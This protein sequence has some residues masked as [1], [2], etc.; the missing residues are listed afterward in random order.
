MTKE[1]LINKITDCLCSEYQSV[2]LINTEDMTMRIFEAD[3]ETSVPD[4]ITTVDAMNSYPKARDWYVENV[5]VERD[6]EKVYALSDINTI[7]KNLSENKAY[8]VEY[9][10]NCAGSMNYNQLCYYKLDTKEGESACILLGFRDIDIRKKAEID[11]LTGLY[12]RQVFFQKA[13]KMVSENPDVQFDIIMSDI[14]DF[15]KVNET[16]GAHVA[17]KILRWTGKFLSPFMNDDLLIGRYGGDQIV[18]FG[19]HEVIKE[20]GNGTMSHFLTLE[21]ENGLPNVVV[22]FGVY[23]NINHSV[24]MVANCDNAHIAVNSI[25]YQYDQIVAKY[26][27]NLKGKMNTQ[28]KIED[29]MHQSLQNGDFK[30]FYQPKHDAITG[31]IIGAEALVRWIHPEYG[32]MS[33]GDFIPLFEKNGFVV[34]IDAF[35]W[36]KSCENIRKWKDEGIRTVPISV[37]ASKLTFAMPD[38]ITKMQTHVMRNI[39]S[40]CDLHI[41]ITETLMTENIEELVKKLNTMRLLGYQVELDDFGS[42]FSSMNALSTLPLDVVKLDMSFMKEFGDEKKSK[43]LG[44]CINLAKVLGYKTVSEGVETKD[45]CDV[46]GF[47]GVDYIQGYHYSKPLPEEEFKEYLRKHI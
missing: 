22:K 45:Q 12:T 23:E 44:A 31:K 14:V 11:D 39:L 27:N 7:L 9:N 29:S 1:E 17:D 25:K 4:A 3:Y 36:G 24:P 2:W 46:L 40:P 26:D 13:E 33:P 28:R 41:E 10:R 15:K 42:G 19:S 38:L 21:K 20:T 6:R 30:V 43:V 8:F 35:V 16:Y 34:E 37:N 5:V 47:L 32:F 18:M